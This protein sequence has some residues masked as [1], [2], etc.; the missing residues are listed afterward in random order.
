M[1][2]IGSLFLRHSSIGGCRLLRWLHHCCHPVCLMISCSPL[3]LLGEG[4][5]AKIFRATEKAIVKDLVVK[6]MD[7][8]LYTNL[9]VDISFHVLDGLRRCGEEALEVADD[10]GRKDFEGPWQRLVVKG[11]TPFCVLM[12]GKGKVNPWALSISRVRPRALL[13]VGLCQRKSSS[14]VSVRER[15]AGR[16]RG[17][18]AMAGP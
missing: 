9:G 1:S 3:A 7:R 16:S 15:C 5:F 6:K 4:T 2:R 8:I 13:A 17:P 18:C 10:F 12:G 14:R 11:N